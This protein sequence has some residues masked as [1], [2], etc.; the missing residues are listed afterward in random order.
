MDL[1]GIRTYCL[2][3]PG[4]EESLPFGP[5]ALVFKTGNKIFAILS[6]GSERSWINL[7]C[8]PAYALELREAHSE[9]IPGYHMNKKHWN[10]IFLDG[11]LKSVFLKK[12]ID[13]SYDLVLSLRPGKIKSTGEV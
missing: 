10:T 5:D 7:K 12:L 1:D 9:I 13:H 6:L 3:K 4:V 2:Q 11:G 8:E